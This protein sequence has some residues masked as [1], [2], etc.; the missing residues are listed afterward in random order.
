MKHTGIGLENFIQSFYVA[1]LTYA[2]RSLESVD[3]AYDD[4]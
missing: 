3:D 4:V 1:M 2:T